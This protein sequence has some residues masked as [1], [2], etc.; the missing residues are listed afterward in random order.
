MKILLYPDQRLTKKC[1]EVAKEE[2]SLLDGT[3]K[4]MRNLIR[5]ENGAALAAPQVGILKRFFVTPTKVFINPIWRP[6][7]QAGVL[8]VEEGCLSFPGL[9]VRKRRYKSIRVA[10]FDM[11]G[12]I[13]EEQLKDFGAQVVQHESDHLNGVLFIDE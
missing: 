1:S 8:I 4:R 13:H 6:F 2:I 5:K 7:K 9:F 10:Y 11:E 3:V 12:K